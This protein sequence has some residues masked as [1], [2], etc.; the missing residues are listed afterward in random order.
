MPLTPEPPDAAAGGV[1]GGWVTTATG[2]TSTTVT[3]QAGAE[4]T[5]MPTGSTTAVWEN[6]YPTAVVTY[7]TQVAGTNGAYFDGQGTLV[8]PDRELTPER[9]SEA[10]QAMRAQA[11]AN[12]ARARA[13][14]EERRRLRDEQQAAASERGEAMLRMV[15]SPAELAHYDQTGDIIV[16]GSDG[17]RYRIG[18]GIVGNVYL[19][20][21]AGQV[22]A[23][24]CCHPVQNGLPHR[25]SHAVQVLALRND[26]ETFRQTA[27]IEWYQT[28]AA[29]RQRNLAA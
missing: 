24:L 26:A 3:L 19:L 16:T 23:A 6:W 17:C 10:Y 12:D 28:P 20:D 21:D 27:N 4:W 14:W 1:W 13:E 9:R 25:D 15:L 2:W 29:R 8:E 7:T 11:E 22:A 18:P 5:Q